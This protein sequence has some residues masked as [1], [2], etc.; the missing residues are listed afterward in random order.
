MSKR[1]KAP[2]TMTGD[3]ERREKHREWLAQYR[4]RPEARE[5]DRI[6]AGCQGSPTP[7]GPSCKA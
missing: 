2:Q 6:R 7:M 1:K 5:E 3:S 4:K